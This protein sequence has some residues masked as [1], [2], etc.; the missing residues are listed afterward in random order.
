MSYFPESSFQKKCFKMFKEDSV[1]IPTQ[2]SRILRFFPDGPIM[3]LDAHQCQEASNSSRLH[4]S[5]CH[6]NTFGRSSEFDKN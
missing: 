4:P 6:V 3:R 1:Q 5:G 2:R